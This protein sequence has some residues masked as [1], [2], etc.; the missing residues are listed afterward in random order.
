MHVSPLAG[1]DTKRIDSQKEKT[2]SEIRKLDWRTVRLHQERKLL[3]SSLGFPRSCASAH[4]TTTRAVESNWKLQFKK[5]DARFAETIFTHLDAMAMPGVD[6]KCVLLPF[7]SNIGN[8][9]ADVFVGYFDSIIVSIKW[10]RYH[11]CVH[12]LHIWIVVADVSGQWACCGNGFI[13]CEED[14]SR[15]TGS[16]PTLRE[17]E[18]L[19]GS[20]P[21][22]RE[23]ER[24][25]G[26]LPTLGECERMKGSLPTL[27]ECE[28]PKGF[29]PTLEECERTKGSLSTL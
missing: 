26:S 19:K 10:K 3:C 25:K 16:L 12:P 22:L 4:A 27:E 1:E 13:S 9:S 14:L 17:Y 29:L 15:R 24:I 28:Q 21:T 23:C 18:Q 6:F 5:S 20:L 2:S 7:G 8:L 11:L